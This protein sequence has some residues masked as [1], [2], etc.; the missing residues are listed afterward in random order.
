MFTVWFL[1]GGG[2]PPPA[3]LLGL[4]LAYDVFDGSQRMEI[5]KCV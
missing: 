1:L 4:G 3:T 2:K 5:F